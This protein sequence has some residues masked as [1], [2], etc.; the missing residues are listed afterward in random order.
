MKPVF[1]FTISFGD[2]VISRVNFR[3]LIENL[4]RPAMLVSYPFRGLLVLKE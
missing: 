3:N 2:A 1:I 4:L